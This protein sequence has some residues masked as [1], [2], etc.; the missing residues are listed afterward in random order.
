MFNNSTKQILPYWETHRNFTSLS[1][2]PSISNSLGQRNLFVKPR[3]KIRSSMAIMAITIKFKLTKEKI[4]LFQKAKC[5][6]QK[7]HPMAP[8]HNHFSHLPIHH[9]V[10]PEP[11]E[12][13]A[14]SSAPWGRC[15]KML[16]KCVREM[17]GVSTWLRRQRRVMRAWE[18]AWKLE[19]QIQTE[20]SSPFL[21][22]VGAGL[23]GE[24]E[25][26]SKKS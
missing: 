3:S 17:K 18:A 1:L 13:W 5:P 2:Q 19:Q 26:E 24:R 4:P 6:E 21:V 8:T 10:C 22:E 20:V 25:R 23:G 7:P 12:A 9:T 11:L 16:C 15:L 14:P